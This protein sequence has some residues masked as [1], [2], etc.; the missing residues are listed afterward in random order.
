MSPRSANDMKKESKVSPN[1][2]AN[3]INIQKRGNSKILHEASQRKVSEGLIQLL[4]DAYKFVRESFLLL[5][6][7]A[8][9]D[10][11]REALRTMLVNLGMSD[12]RLDEMLART[13]EP[14]N[15][16]A[17]LAIMSEMYYSFPQKSDLNLMFDT[18][19]NKNNELDVRKLKEALLEEGLTHE[20]ID[21]VFERHSKLTKQGTSFDVNSFITAMSIS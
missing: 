13:G 1:Q 19:R 6:S 12:K 14:V 20:E 16:A 15:F 7:E 4:P 17:Y 3:E 2:P 8:K 9:G 11:T 5:D 21:K 10:I 18:F